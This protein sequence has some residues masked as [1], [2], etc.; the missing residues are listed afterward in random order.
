[1]TKLPDHFIKFQ[2]SHPRVFAS[3]EALGQAASAEGPLSKKEV[4]LVKLATAAGAGLEGAVHAHC[5]RALEAG[6]SADEI[7]HAV[8]LGVTTLGFPSMMAN[9]CRVDEIIARHNQS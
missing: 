3:Y 7:R 6:C 4:S 2:E 1:M 9:L 5:R 8:I